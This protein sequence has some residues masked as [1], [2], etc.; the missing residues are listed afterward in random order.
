VSVGAQ[1]DGVPQ[2]ASR[3][4]RRERPRL[5]ALAVVLGALL[6][7]PGCKLAGYPAPTTSLRLRGNVADAQV[8]IDDIVLGSLAY[9]SQHGVALP[10]GRHRVTIEKAGYFPWD[11][12][13]EAEEKLIQLQ[14]NLIAIPD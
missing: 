10:P 12:L 8:S 13:V 7:S 1:V 6:A 2:R 5:G 4:A 9:V 3:Y 11:A 14:V